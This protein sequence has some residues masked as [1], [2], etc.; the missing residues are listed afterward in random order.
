MKKNILAVI[1]LAATLV[2]LTLSAMMLFVFVP[3][4]NKANNLITSVISLVDLEIKSGEVNNDV[5][6]NV[7]DL[8]TKS[9]ITGENVSLKKGADGKIHYAGAVSASLSLHK[10]DKDYEAKAVLIDN[11][12]EVIK[13]IIKTEISKYT[14]DEVSVD[15]DVIKKQIEAEVLKELKKM[16]DSNFIYKVTIGF[17]CN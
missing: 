8:E 10:K 11:Q 7:A 3:Y 14:I 13:D 15:Y 12:L 1:I 5:E 4:V 16:F 6:I 9:V 17:I 2:N